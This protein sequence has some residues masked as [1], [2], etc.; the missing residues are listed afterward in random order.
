LIARLH[1]EFGWLPWNTLSDEERDVLAETFRDEAIVPVIRNANL[2]LEFDL[3][4]PLDHRIWANPFKYYDW[5]IAESD[6]ALTTVFLKFIDEQ[7]Q[8]RGITPRTA[9]TTSVKPVSWR[10]VE[11]LDIRHYK[12]RIFNGNERKCHSEA[13]KN[14]RAAYDHREDLLMQSIPTGPRKS[15]RKDA[16]EKIDPKSCSR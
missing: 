13:R 10:Q 6:N 4:A 16:S 14:A 3:N 8:A 2:P 5:N 7:R 1:R 11:L 12:V 9:N 15:I